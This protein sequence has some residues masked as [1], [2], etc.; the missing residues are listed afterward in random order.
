MSV[1]PISSIADVFAGTI[2]YIFVSISTTLFLFIFAIFMKYKSTLKEKSEPFKTDILNEFFENKIKDLEKS[3]EEQRERF[4]EELISYKDKPMNKNSI[5]EITDILGLFSEEFLERREKEKY[6][7]EFKEKMANIYTKWRVR[8]SR[9]FY[10]WMALVVFS[11]IILFILQINYSGIL[12]YLQLLTLISAIIGVILFLITISYIIAFVRFHF[13]GDVD[14]FLDYVNQK[15]TIGLLDT[16]FDQF[17][18]F[19]QRRE[20]LLSELS[21]YSDV[22]PLSIYPAIKLLSLILRKTSKGK[23][24]KP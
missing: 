20:T 17:V 19:R 7:D 10:S 11:A 5:A 22:M 23:Q 16:K 9:A 8:V 13:F 3:E 14:D 12:A 6:L 21:E 15:G 2:Y 1:V 18:S 4:F 24:A